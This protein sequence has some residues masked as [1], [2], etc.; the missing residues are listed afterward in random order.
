MDALPEVPSSISSNHMEVHKHLQWD[1]M[2]SFVMQAYMQIEPPY[3]EANTSLKKE[4]HL[5]EGRPIV[6]NV[7][8]FYSCPNRLLEAKVKC[9]GLIAL[10]EEIS[11]QPSMNGVM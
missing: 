11:K 1:V 9:F 4:I 8:V 2:P 5:K 6:K 10:A 7:T 3:T